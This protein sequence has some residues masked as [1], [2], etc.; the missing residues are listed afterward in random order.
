MVNYANSIVY[1]LCCLDPQVE[2]IYVGSTTSFRKRKANHKRSCTK[3]S[4][5]DYY[6]PVYQYIR[7]NGDW[8]NWTMII[9]RKY[10]HL[11]DK[12]QL[13]Q[14]ESKYII[15]LK[16][17]LNKRI[18]LRTP[19]EYYNDNKEDIL[20]KRKQYVENHREEVRQ[21]LKKY[22]SDNKA[23]FSQK[24]EVYKRNNKDEIKEQRKAY[25]EQNKL[26]VLDERRKYRERNQCEVECSC[27]IMVKKLYLSTHIKTKKH[28]RLMDE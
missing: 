11:T 24:N 5:K 16:A 25:Y 27:G 10:P 19:K 20:K 4:D 17:S 26:K 7:D 3:P 13:R 18:P 21:G 28:K 15:K 22:Y 12:H 1:K 8:E 2:G 6:Q 9:V 14:K 23:V